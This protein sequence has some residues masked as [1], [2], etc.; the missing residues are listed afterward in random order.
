MSTRTMS[1]F[2]ALALGGCGGA[3][4]EAD[5]PSRAPSKTSSEPM[6]L[7]DEATPMPAE[8]DEA[9]P[10]TAADAATSADEGDSES[11]DEGEGDGESDD[12]GDNESDGE[13]SPED[14]GA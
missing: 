11:D 14:E 6:D 5:D 4:L 12:E 1:C 2:L 10:E 3:Q 13:E 7:D 8:A 9:E